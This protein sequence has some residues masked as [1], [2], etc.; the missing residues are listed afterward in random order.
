M[1][2][3]LV[4]RALNQS[5]FVFFKYILKIYTFKPGYYCRTSPVDE[6]TFCITFSFKAEG[7]TES[8]LIHRG[9]MAVISGLDL[10]FV[11]VYTKL[12]FAFC[13]VRYP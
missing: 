1:G 6:C 7:Y 11:T 2:S 4:Y 10:C 3:K 9:C 12:I 13:S 8:T 5:L